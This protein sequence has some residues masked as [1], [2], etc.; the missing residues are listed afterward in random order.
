MSKDILYGLDARI[1]LRDGINKLADTVKTTIGPLG[2]NAIIER[3]YGAPLITNDGV[4][5]AKE[6]EF[7]DA[8][9][10]LGAQLVKEVAIK[11]NEVA[12]DGTTTATVLAQA[13]IN[14]CFLAIEKGIKPVILRNNLNII[15]EKLIEELEKMA[16]E[17]KDTKDIERVGTISSA[18]KEI[19]SLIALAMDAVGRDGIVTIEEGNSL[20]TTLSVVNG[21][22]FDR[23]YLSQY[24]ITDSNKM[25]TEYQNTFVLLSSLPL[26]DINKI[27]HVLEHSKNNNTPILLIA[28]EISEDLL[29]ILCTNNVQGNLK[30]VAIKSPGFGDNKKALLEDVAAFTGATILDENNF[31]G[32]E[33]ALPEYLGFIGGCKVT[34]SKTTIVKGAGELKNIEKRKNHIKYLISQ[35]KNEFEKEQLENRL[36]NIAGGVALITIGA[37]TEVELKEKKLRIEDALNATKAAVEEG[38][39]PGG[40]IALLNLYRKMD[41]NVKEKISTDY[42]IAH[43]VLYESLL[44][45]LYNILTNSGLDADTIIDDLKQENENIGFDAFNCC[46]CNMIDSGI[47]DPVKVTKSALSNAVSIVSTVITMGSALISIE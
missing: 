39:V 12:G 11:T 10:N 32:N 2:N 36:A 38:I 13:L 30:C 8:Y 5:I 33:K 22:E 46:K 15:S 19:G 23:G 29:S 42:S 20:E 41:L 44:S 25:I 43:D 17:I 28:D 6:I 16:I 47:I 31:F 4:T 35:C 7:K 45:P 26:N 9:E 34:K 24:M 18:S 27:L 21:M 1:K 40:G 3:S 14:K 37:V